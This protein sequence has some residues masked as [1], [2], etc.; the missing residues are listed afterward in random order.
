MRW[1]DAIT[2]SM[3][4][5]LSKVQ[6]IVKDREAWHAVVRGD[7]CTHPPREGGQRPSACISSRITTVIQVGTQTDLSKK[8]GG[9]EKLISISA[10]Q[11]RG[12]LVQ[13]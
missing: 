12:N 10:K 3:G 7:K 13:V 1:L 9:G 4:M 5:S 8:K 6:E 2:N 11:S